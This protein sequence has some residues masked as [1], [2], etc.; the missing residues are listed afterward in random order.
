MMS[1]R[2]VAGVCALVMA[3]ALIGVP[4]SRAQ[5]GGLTDEQVALLDRVFAA[6]EL[7]DVLESYVEDSAGTESQTLTVVLGEQSLDLADLTEWAQTQTVINT[8]EGKNVDAQ[9]SATVTSQGEVAFSVTGEAR[10][11]DGTLYV[12]A[13][14]DDPSA[15]LPPLPEGWMIVEDAET[16]G[17]EFAALGALQLDSLADDEPPMLFEDQERMREIASDVFV[18]T[19]TLE[20]GSEADLITIVFGRDALIAIVLED[21]DDPFQVGMFSALNEDSQATL[22]VL[23]DAEGRALEVISQMNMIAQD[24]DAAALSP[25]DFPPGALLSFAFQGTDEQRY[26]EFEAAVEPVAAPEELAS[27][28]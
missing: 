9:I 24:I 19:V 12:N 23:L 20:D 26:S 21:T 17:D 16:I 10:L 15:D 6:R 14:Y 25:E 8:P 18:E 3:L 13:A 1:K 22:S 4:P 28:D 5:D 27:A 2:F 7:V 11:V